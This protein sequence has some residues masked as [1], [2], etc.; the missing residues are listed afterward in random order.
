MPAPVP[1]QPPNI[2]SSRVISSIPKFT[3]Y[4]SQ[5]A[6]IYTPNQ[7]KSFWDNILHSEASKS[8]LTKISREVLEGRSIDKFSKRYLCVSNGN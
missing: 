2:F 5:R 1:L 4:E 3:G 6:G 7:L 8:V